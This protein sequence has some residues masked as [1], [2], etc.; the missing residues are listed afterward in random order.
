MGE[1]GEKKPKTQRKKPLRSPA[2]LKE[3]LELAGVT[4]MPV[5]YFN[6]QHCVIIFSQDALLGL[7]AVSA[8]SLCF[9]KHSPIFRVLMN[10]FLVIRQNWGMGSGKGQLG[11]P[12]RTGPRG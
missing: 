7:M 2:F 3:V 12:R 1:I 4:R 9:S 11:I 8:L 6:Q 10:G 5:V